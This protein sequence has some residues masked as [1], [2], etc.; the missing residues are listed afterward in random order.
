MAFALTSP[1]RHCDAKE[2]QKKGVKCDHLLSVIK[3]FTGHCISTQSPNGRNKNEWI[4]TSQ[5]PV[6]TMESPL[7]LV[8][9]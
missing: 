1:P 6:R 5:C 4:Y 8:N 3:R 2:E 9:S 7:G